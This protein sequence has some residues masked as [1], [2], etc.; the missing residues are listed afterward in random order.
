MK[1]TVITHDGKAHMDEVLGIA[2]LSLY[3]GTEPETIIRMDAQKASKMVEEGDIPENTYFI[4]CGLTLDR[5]RKLFD[6]HQNR[7]MDCAALLIFNE[8]FKNLIGTELH[9]YVKLVS[10]I[11]T[12]GAMSLDDFHLVSESR[13]YFSFSHNILLKT[14]EKTPHMVVQ[15]LI[16]G[17]KDKIA[18]EKAKQVAALWR[19]EPGNMEILSINEIKVLRY[20]KKPP[21][22]LVSPLRSEINKLIDEN[23][24]S[25]T[26]SFDDKIDAARTLYRTN[27][28]HNLIDFSKSKPTETLF[29]HLGGFLLKFIPENDK[30]WERLVIE[31]IVT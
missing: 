20:L 6:H 24:I 5:E 27:F 16:F 23:D 15:I 25:V 30:E 7:D 29:C 26:F 22:E 10:K 9:D 11:D 21:S 4:D 28:G 8:F 19:K 14:F 17:L 3:L 18:F 2:L 12:R 13:D 1:Y 31:A